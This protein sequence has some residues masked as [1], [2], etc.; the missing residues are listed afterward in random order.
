MKFNVRDCQIH[1]LQLN[2]SA[3][4]PSSL[5]KEEEIKACRLGIVEDIWGLGGNPIVTRK[6]H[7]TLSKGFS[8]LHARR[9]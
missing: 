1:N 4:I 7:M 5:L 8:Y 3:L 2:L 9:I 6:E